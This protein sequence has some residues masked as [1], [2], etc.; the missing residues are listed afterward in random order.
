VPADLILLLHGAIVAFIGGG[1]VAIVVGRWRQWRWTRDVRFRVAHGVAIGVVVAESWLGVDC[2]LTVWEAR[3]RGDA[4]DGGF[5]AHWLHRLL[6]YDAPPW[7]FTVGY[8]AFGA[9]VAVAWFLAPPTR[10]RD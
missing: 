7:V 10:R 9:A 2:P 3:L 4:M 8:T 1:L 5:V 6:Y